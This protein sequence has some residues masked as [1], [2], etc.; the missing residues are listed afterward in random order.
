MAHNY[1]F[2]DEAKLKEIE[3]LLAGE[4]GDAL[5]AWSLECAK[6]GID[7]HRHGLMRNGLIAAGGAVVAAGG[8]WIAK[9]ALGKT[10]VEKRLEE[11]KKRRDV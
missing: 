8:Y 4:K 3:E 9:K 1:K 6:A 2:M 7:I 11:T 10:R 5:V